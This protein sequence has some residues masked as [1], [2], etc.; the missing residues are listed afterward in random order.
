MKQYYFNKEWKR[1]FL[2]SVYHP[3]KK[4]P[5][6]NGERNKKNFIFSFSFILFLWILSLSIL[7]SHWIH[8]PPCLVAG[9]IILKFPFLSVT[10]TYFSFHSLIWIYLF[11]SF[12]PPFFSWNRRWK[13]WIRSCICSNVHVY[14]TNRV[15]QW[16]YKRYLEH[17]LT[18]F[19][20][21]VKFNILQHIGWSLWL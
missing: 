19:F 16:E 18:I 5:V 15:I 3:S 1:N 17:H 12:F 6:Q 7:S 4:Q 11:F 10:L 20:F 2:Y 21:M 9:C 14:L 13:E 8:A